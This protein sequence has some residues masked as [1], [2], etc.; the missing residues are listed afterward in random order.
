[1]D[2]PTNLVVV[3]P[4]ELKEGL[5]EWA[6]EEDRTLSYIARR[7]LQR[8]LERLERAAQTKRRRNSD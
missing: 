4:E 2:K 8:E 3:V 6:K 5:R 7:A 1:M